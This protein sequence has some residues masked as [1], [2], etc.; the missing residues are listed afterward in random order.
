MQKL[1]VTVLSGFLGF[2]KT[3]LLNHILHTKEGLR[4]TVVDASTFYANLETLE[5]I[6]DRNWADNEDDQRSIAHLLINQVEFADVILLNKLDLVRA[7]EADAVERVIRNL[8]VLAKIIRTKHSRVPLIE[9]L[10]TRRF[11]FDRTSQSAGWIQELENKHVPE[12]LEYGISSLV[13]RDTRPFHP[14]RLREFVAR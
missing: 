3:T 13:F 8:N 2:G 14:E 1:P 10:H 11:D 9:V 12:T 6:Q 7:E 4:V 5:S